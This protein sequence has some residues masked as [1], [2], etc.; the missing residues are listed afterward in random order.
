MGLEDED[1]V[2]ESMNNDLRNGDASP[3]NLPYDGWR[4]KRLSP[5]AC[6]KISHVLAACREGCEGDPLSTLATSNDGLVDDE[7]RRLACMSMASLVD[8]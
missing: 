4:G 6:T 5:A 3:S 2:V 1:V 7:V 8:A